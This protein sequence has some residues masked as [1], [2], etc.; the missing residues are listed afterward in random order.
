MDVSR[1]RVNDSNAMTY[2]YTQ[3]SPHQCSHVVNSKHEMISQQTRSEIPTPGTWTRVTRVIGDLSNRGRPTP[4]VPSSSV[5]A[6]W[7]LP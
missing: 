7:F 2:V 5:V 4:G 1:T 3:A 6:F